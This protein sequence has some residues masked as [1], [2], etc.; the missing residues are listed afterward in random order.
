SSSVHEYTIHFCTL[1]VASGWNTVVLLSTYCQGLNLEIRTAM[2]LYDDTI[3]LESFL[4][5][6]TRVSQ[7]LAA[8]QTLVTAPQSREN[9]W[10][11]G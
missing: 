11:V 10:G 4:Q 5:R 8:C 7:C 6:T 2:V 9:H 3:G 1:T